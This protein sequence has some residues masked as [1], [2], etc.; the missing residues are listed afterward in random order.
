M[1]DGDKIGSKHKYSNDREI[2]GKDWERIGWRRQ[3]L[4]EEDP[5]E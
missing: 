4:E 1:V 3:Y 2:K 5:K